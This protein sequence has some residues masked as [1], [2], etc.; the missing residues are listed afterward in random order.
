[1]LSD[2]WHSFISII[3]NRVP[4]A[5][6]AQKKSNENTKRI[7]DKQEKQ[8][9]IYYEGCYKKCIKNINEA[10]KNGNYFT[11]SDL[12]AYHILLLQKEGYNVV[13]SESYGRDWHGG[14]NNY[15][16]SWKK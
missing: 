5:A 10:S 4:N 8:K 11:Y 15:L 3:T 7:R 16:V 13:E 9:R 6:D 14:A 2:Y 12:S 1:M